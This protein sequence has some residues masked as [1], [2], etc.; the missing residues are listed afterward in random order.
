MTLNTIFIV[1]NY[2]L[3]ATI[4]SPL[5]SGVNFSWSHFHTADNDYKKP[6]IFFLF[7]FNHSP[8]P[9]VYNYPKNFKV[10]T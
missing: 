3:F 2:K 6:Y 5:K 7:L 1:V 4:P 9:R 8:C 10:V